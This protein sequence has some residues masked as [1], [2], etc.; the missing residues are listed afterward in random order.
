MFNNKNI[1]VV[2]GDSNVWGAE[3]PNCPNMQKDFKS[4]VYDPNNIETWPYHIRY[5]FSGVL[6]ERHNM[7]ILNL[8]IPGC[9]NDTIFR[10]INKF[11]QGYY[12]VDLND[13]FVMIFWTSPERREFYS[14]YVGEGRYFNYSPVWSHLYKESIKKKFHKIYSRFV[15]S[16]EF[17]ITKTFNYIYS[18]NALLSHKNIE[19]VQGFSLFKDEIFDLVTEHKL[20]NFL[21][22]QNDSIHT[23]AAKAADHG[24][25]PNPYQ[26][27]G[28]HP[29]ELGHTVIAD[30]YQELIKQR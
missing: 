4:I 27:E 22:Y 13:C 2:F 19:F 16:E 7:Q 17:D 29:T 30:R 23:I 8:S 15:F 21:H 6:A 24:S 20:P 10:R 9:S 28:S 12:P 3:M 26:Y 5:S 14:R 18:S 1:L 11:L 25:C